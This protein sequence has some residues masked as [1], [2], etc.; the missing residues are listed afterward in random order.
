VLLGATVAL[1]TARQQVSATWID[2]R[3]QQRDFAV[4][5]VAEMLGGGDAA[6]RMAEQIVAGDE[7]IDAMTP[8]GTTGSER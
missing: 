1:H 3:N 8:I 5:M 2:G 7:A 6:Q 4:E